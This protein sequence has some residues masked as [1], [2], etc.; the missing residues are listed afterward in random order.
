MG[1]LQSL[2]VP[3]WL[4]PFDL[5][6]P[7]PG[8]RSI[9]VTGRYWGFLAL[10]LSVLG[11]GALW[12]FL[13]NRPG[14]LKAALGVGLALLIQLGAQTTALLSSVV[15]GRPYQP[16][17]WKGSWAR[18]ETVAFIERGGRLQ[19]E[20][21][22]PVRAVLDCYDEDDIP[23]AGMDP[24]TGLVRSVTLEKGSGLEGSTIRA[25]FVTWSRIRID[26]EPSP[27]RSVTPDSASQVEVVLNQA[28]HHTWTAAGGTLARGGRNNLALCCDEARLCDGP[29]DLIFHDPVSARGWTVSRI[30]WPVWLGCLTALMVCRAALGQRPGRATDRSAG[31]RPTRPTTAEAFRN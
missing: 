9:G 3:R 5:L 26:L 6:R 23:H 11:A 24:G 12:V 27:G 7:L 18:G 10:P 25:R 20:L 19:G 22:T 1:S 15:S 14:T 2:H 29:V 4:S 17:E 28:Y 21:I 13:S 8:F 30:A 31:P 16:V